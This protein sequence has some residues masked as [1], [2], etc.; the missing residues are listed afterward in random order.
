[1]MVLDVR[2]F[3]L[4]V[5]DV[6]IREKKRACIYAENQIKEEICNE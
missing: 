6:E 4:R 2:F 1:M 3:F 5:D